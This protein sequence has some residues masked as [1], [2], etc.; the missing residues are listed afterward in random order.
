[1][2]GA[3]LNPTGLKTLWALVS[4][5]LQIGED[6]RIQGK[7]KLLTLMDGQGRGGEEGG[8]RGVLLGREDQVFTQGM[9]GR[10]QYARVPLQNSLPQRPPQAW[11]SV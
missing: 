8:G 6:D 9:V 1:M 5:D 3:V 2:P 11:F 4:R 10:G 7:W